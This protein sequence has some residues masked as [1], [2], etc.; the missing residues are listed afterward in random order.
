M[1][2]RGSGFWGVVLGDPEE[3]VYV[4][5]TSLLAF[6]DDDIHLDRAQHFLSTMMNLNCSFKTQKVWVTMS[7][8]LAAT[9]P[10]NRSS[11]LN[12]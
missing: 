2:I 11:L 4:G 1:L 8:Q 3:R 12:G 6:I 7:G 5:E 10:S 9:C